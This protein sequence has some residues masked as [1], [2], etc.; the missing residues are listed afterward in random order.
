M[1]AM[2]DVQMTDEKL[3]LDSILLDPNNPRLL[4]LD[5]YEGVPEERVAEPKV[6]EATL[7]RINTGGFDMETLRASIANSG[8]LQVDRIVV[9][10]IGNKQYVAVEGNRRI[11]A[12][13]TL[14]AQ[15]EAGERT[16]SDRVKDT[17][18]DRRVLVL[19]DADPT[20]ARLSQWVIQGVRHISGIRPWG[21]YQSARTIQAM[22]EGL[23]YTEDQV[24]AAL[25]FSKARVRRSMKVFLC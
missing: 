17:V 23:S 8:L 10:K 9:R 13:K 15:H 25:G 21:A 1:L 18:A 16:L 4:G 3:S 24:V 19:Q 12:C 5:G 2:L 14:L 6:Q 22:I 11:A 7:A 20:H